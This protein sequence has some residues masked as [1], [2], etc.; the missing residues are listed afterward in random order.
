LEEKILA[1][2]V[3][4]GGIPD[5]LEGSHGL[6]GNSESFFDAI[7]VLETEGDTGSKILEVLAEGY[8][9]VFYCN[10]LGFSSAF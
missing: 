7:V 3:K 2:Y 4:V 9:S 5:V 10:W 8:R 6:G 1:P